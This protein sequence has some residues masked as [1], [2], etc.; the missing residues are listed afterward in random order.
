MLALYLAYA[1]NKDPAPRAAG[2]N[3]AAASL[4][5]P[6][7]LQHPRI[8]ETIAIGLFKG[9]RLSRPYVFASKND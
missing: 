4:D 9:G 7:L 1:R 2:K 6:K 3:R 5:W 8:G